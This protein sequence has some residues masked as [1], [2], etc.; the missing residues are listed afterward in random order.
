MPSGY[1]RFPTLHDDT[2]VFAC[3]DDLWTVSARGGIPRRLT[4]APAEESSPRLS[5]DGQWVA[6]VGRDEGAEEVYLMPAL[7]GAPRR[8]THLGS[9]CTVAGWTS[10]GRIVFASDAGQPFWQLKFL[11]AL[12]PADPATIEPIPCGPARAIAY[13][14]RGKGAVIGR[15]TADPARWKRYRGGS[16]GRLWIDPRGA[17]E[18]RPLI[19]LDSNLASPMWLQDNRVYFISD[20]E[21]VGNVYSC[22]PSGK[23]LRRHT[24]H[25][26]FYARNAAS[27]GKRIVY[28]AGADLF[29]LDPATGESRAIG[30]D[31][32]SPQTQRQRRFSSATEY[33]ESYALS[34]QGGRLAV[35]SRGKLFTFH[36]WDG[37]VTQHGLPDARYRVPFWVTET[38]IGA[39]SD[40][41][42]EE[43]VV[44]FNLGPEPPSPDEKD[45]NL[46]TGRITAVKIHPTKSRLAFTNHRYELMV[47]EVKEGEAGADPEPTLITVDRGVSSPIHGFD[48]SPDGEWLAYGCSVSLQRT[49][50][51]LWNAET[52]E[53][54]QITHPILSDVSP[55]FDPDG[56]YLY[57]LSYRVFDPVYD[58]MQFELSF[59][60]GMVPCLVTLRADLPSPF[61][62]L[63]P[64]DQVEDKD[65]KKDASPAPAADSAPAGDAPGERAA[66]ADAAHDA[67]PQP[68]G[69]PADEKKQDR[70]RIDLEGIANR[71]LAFPVAEGRYGKI[72]GAKG[73]KKVLWTY[74]FSEPTLHDAPDGEHEEDGGTLESFDF[75]TR[76]AESVAENVGGFTLSADAAWLA[77]TV[78]RH[79]RVVRVGERPE[80]SGPPRKRGWINLERVKVNIDPPVE[81]RQMFGEAWRLQRDHFWTPDMSQVDWQ[82]VHNGYLP[83]VERVSSRSEF[84]DLMW[85]MQGELGTSHCYEY[86]GDYRPHLSVYSQGFLGADFAWDDGR[87]AW[88]ITGIAQGDAW[89]PKANSSLNMPG[90]DARLGDSLLAINGVTLSR[91]LSPAMALVNQAG[92]DVALTLARGLPDEGGAPRVVIV[93]TLQS[94]RPARYRAWVEGNRARVHAATQGRAGYLHI[95]DMGPRGFAEFHRSFLAES[96]RDALV[97]DARYN[98]GGHVSE[99]IL[100][101]LS[102]KRLGYTVSRWAQ[103]PVPYPAYSVAG[104]MVAITNEHAGSDGDIFSHGFK[105]LKLGPLIGARTWGGVIGIS[106]SHTLADGTTTTQPEFATWFHDAEWR[107]ENFG[108]EPDIAVDD[109]PRDWAAGTDAQLERAITEVMRRLRRRP[110]KLPAFDQRPSRAIPRL[111]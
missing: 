62:P 74:Y 25:Q 32:R 37:P 81:W 3:E 82:A 4:A 38:A 2:V 60:R 53:T 57:F 33:L 78:R 21:G 13:A 92:A 23:R 73:G 42:G 111:E 106:P 34:P 24:H 110:P 51:K 14:P 90:V 26:D 54:H 66:P 27:D 104:P 76:A 48:W 6:F 45:L 49:A 10:D 65:E 64:S 46:D 39:I 63:P 19:E 22:T 91:S 18:W 50:I 84:S 43:K 93:K 79:L 99:L 7:G 29:L 75:E 86:G 41:G 77:Y 52:R 1:Y 87:G 20:H 100:E 55:A 68:A 89:H 17:G 88:R 67:Q 72:A 16:A 98:G 107:L 40:E 96:E 69:A 95:P 85:E 97:V 44:A 94:E 103:V 15:N 30:I 80:D 71:V 8:L 109:T 61:T 70:T 28:H 101:K 56:R 11:Y 47:V 12:D 83:L 35:T 31:W 36:N 108:A 59:P 58:N 102:R 5:P 9:S 105:A